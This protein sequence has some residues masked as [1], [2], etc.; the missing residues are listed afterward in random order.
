M[1]VS[2]STAGFVVRA[3]DVATLYGPLRAV[4][5]PPAKVRVAVRKPSQRL[6]R[7]FSAGSG[8]NVGE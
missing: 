3:S 6:S 1:T 5:R 4:P 7:E 8:D 2:A